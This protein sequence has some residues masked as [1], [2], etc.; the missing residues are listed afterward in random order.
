MRDRPVRR[1]SLR[2]T[3]LALAMWLAELA[4]ARAEPDAAAPVR[5][6]ISAPEILRAG[7]HANVSIRVQL[8]ADGGSPL[9]LTP[10]IEGTAIEAMRGRLLRADAKSHGEGELIFEL[11]ILAHGEGT[12]ILHIELATY[13]CTPRCRYTAVRESQVLRVSAR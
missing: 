13:V 4:P 1:L 10:S 2:V 11:P 9:V 8:A 12:A 7:D 3:A 6:T 5:V